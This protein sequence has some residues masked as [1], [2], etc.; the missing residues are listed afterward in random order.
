M[1]ILII[2]PELDLN[3]PSGM[4]SNRLIHL[5]HISNN[6]EVD[7]WIV[8]DGPDQSGKSYLEN[9]GVN[10][11]YSGTVPAG[12][13]NIL[14]RS[15]LAEYSPIQRFSPLSNTLKKLTERDYDV[16]KVETIGLAPLIK[17]FADVPVVWSLVD[18]PSFRKYRLYKY[19]SNTKWR[20]K[21]YIEWKIAYRMEKNYSRYAD[22]I[23]VV[24]KQ[25]AEYLNNQFSNINACAIPVVLPKKFLSFP[26]VTKSEN[27]IVVLGNREL[28]YIRNG[29]EEYI[30]PALQNLS[31]SIE[32]LNVVFLGRGSMSIP[33]S[34]SNFVKQP[35]WVDDYVREL[36]QAS[37]AV[38][39]DPV[40]SGIKNRTVQCLALG[41]PVV[42]TRY[43]F[44]GIEINPESVGYEVDTPEEFHI[45]LDEL[46]TNVEL[47]NRMGEH[48]RKF[49][50]ERFKSNNIMNS[51]CSL[52][53]RV[54]N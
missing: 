38:V 19:Y 46:L 35:D 21:A 44:E 1:D 50:I 49:A 3:K 39:P 42:G 37:A 24:S 29:I 12:Q 43:A 14:A 32:Q 36:A 5:E 17:A 48:G 22:A 53:N 9:K 7:V 54:S 2:Y 4:D 13:H 15:L 18:S 40:G 27:K 47:R 33:E 10:T 6:H 23:H 30:L 51:W 8:A 26:Q 52:Y 16:V 34:H 11:L 31:R 41:I 25:E 28:P 45:A 20:S